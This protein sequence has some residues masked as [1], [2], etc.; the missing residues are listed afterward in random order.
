MISRSLLFAAVVILLAFPGGSPIQ[1]QDDSPVTIA[2]GSLT[3]DSVTP[4]T[5]FTSSGTSSKTHPQTGKAVTQVAITMPG[6]NQVLTFSGQK[7]TV[8][9]RY[10]AT[11]ITVTTGNNG[12]G[13]RVDT[14]FNSFRAAGANRLEHTNRTAKISRVVVTRGNQTLFDNAA[15]G[16]TKIVISYR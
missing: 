14:D 15:S 4:W 5:S 10:A 6:H 12:R 13:M 9:I 7:C 16:G 11:D 1:A 8:A 2:D 3:M